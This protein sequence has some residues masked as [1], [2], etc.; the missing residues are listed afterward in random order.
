MC[1]GKVLLRS[2]WHDTSGVDGKVADV[3]VGFNVS[4]IN[5]FSHTRHLIQLA[6]IAA[7]SRIV[8][9][10]LTVCFEVAKVHGIKADQGGE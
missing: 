4:H 2:Q 9:Y 6:H 8:C 3:V 1:L 7:N 10:L 5:G